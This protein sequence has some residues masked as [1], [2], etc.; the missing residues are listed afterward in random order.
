MN[1]QEVQCKLCKSAPERPSA[2]APKRLNLG[3]LPKR[4]VTRCI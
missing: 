2:A 1:L 4:E 3:P